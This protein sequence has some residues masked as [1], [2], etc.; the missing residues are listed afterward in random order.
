MQFCTQEEPRRHA[1]SDMRTP[2]HTGIGIAAVSCSR[3]AAKQAG[4][5]AD[6]ACLGRGA[7]GSKA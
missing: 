4:Y 5:Q 2:F 7:T 1:A 3:Q 6:E